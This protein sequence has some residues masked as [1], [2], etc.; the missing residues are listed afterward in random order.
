MK[1]N[2]VLDAYEG[3]MRQCDGRITGISTSLVRKPQP[4]HYKNIVE[5]H[6]LCIEPFMAGE[7]GQK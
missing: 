3:L 4:F 6:G 1:K 2:V 7:N 5:I